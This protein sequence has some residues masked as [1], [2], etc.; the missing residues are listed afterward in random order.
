M[1]IKRINTELCNG[2]GLCIE[3]CPTDVLRLD[4]KTKKAFI[5]YIRDCQS[6][7]MC[8][9]ECPTGAITVMPVFERRM[10]LAW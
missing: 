8:E 2:C 6:C 4:E 1:G 7:L 5:K 3:Y 10:P 9:M